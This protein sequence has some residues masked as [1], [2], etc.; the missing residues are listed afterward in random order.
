MMNAL[1]LLE[2]AKIGAISPMEIAEVAKELATGADHSDQYTLIHILGV[3]GATEHE[4][5]VAR[6][7]DVSSDPMLPRIALQVLCSHWG[8]VH[9]YQDEIEKF[10][11]GVH[12]DIDRDVQLVALSAMGELLRERTDKSL[13]SL[14]VEIFTSPRERHLVRQ[15]AYFAL[16][17]AYGQEWAQL[18][19]ASRKI[20][21]EKEVDPQVLE[22][23]LKGTA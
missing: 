20:D 15:A 12:W 21:L 14:L 7:L 18:P 5:I 13:L 2:K 23:A 3:S 4:A 16:A 9:R 1:R 11:R 6:F 17:R 8:M 10:A 19:P 22:W